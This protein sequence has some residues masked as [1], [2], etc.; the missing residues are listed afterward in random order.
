VAAARP[1]APD[2]ILF[3]ES[4][5]L[6]PPYR[7]VSPDPFAQAQQPPPAQVAPLSPPPPAPP[8][9]RPAFDPFADPLE[10]KVAKPAAPASSSEFDDAFADL[11]R[12]MTSEPSEPGLLPGLNPVVTRVT[13]SPVM[14]DPLAVPDGVSESRPIQAADALGGWTPPGDAP[15][16]RGRAAKGLLGALAVLALV[17]GAGWGYLTW[18][19]SRAASPPKSEGLGSPPIALSG[20]PVSSTTPPSTT[21]RVKPPP[22]D[23]PPPW[24]QEPG[25]KH[26]APAQG[27]RPSQAAAVQGTPDAPLDEA[28]VSATFAKYAP[29][30]DACAEQARALNPDLQ[31]NRNVGLSLTVNPDGKVADPT[32]DDQELDGGELGKCIRRASAQMRFPSFDGDPIRVHQ[33][34]TLR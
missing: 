5:S 8:K 15:A 22:D 24:E 28:V 6:A 1:P 34:I 11:G 20:S 18:S 29:K 25:A 31:L 30:L 26:R 21:P 17:G 13:A 2:E 9:Q 23:E 3:P 14:L 33:S 19:K 10:A 12:E 4:D 32:L 16:R 7:V 27:Q